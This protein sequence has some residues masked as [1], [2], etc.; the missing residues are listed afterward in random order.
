MSYG[1]YQVLQ[2]V[3]GGLI[4]VACWWVRRSG[5]ALALV[6]GL[7]CC[8]MTALGPATES[9]TYVLLGPTA[10]WLVVSGATE[11]HPIGLRIVWLAGYALLVASQ[12][13]ALLPGEWGRALKSLGP[14]P[15][16]ALLLLGGQLYLAFRRPV[17]TSCQLVGRDGT[18]SWQLVATGAAAGARR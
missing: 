2:A 18:T 11:R 4:A 17:A 14:Q 6:L 3:C 16:A 15:A 5:G 8:W 10:A 9:A 7:G 12:A 1:T 13:V